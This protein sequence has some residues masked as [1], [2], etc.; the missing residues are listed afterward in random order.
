MPD[1]I[2]HPWIAGRARND[3]GKAN[4]IA[5]SPLRGDRDGRQR[6]QG[7]PEAAKKAESHPGVAFMDIGDCRNI[8]AS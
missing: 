7:L 6:P 3:T 2:R 4:S 8:R 1:V 5:F